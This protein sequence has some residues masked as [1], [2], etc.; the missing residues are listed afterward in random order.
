MGL[1]RMCARGKQGIAGW[2]LLLQAAAAMATALLLLLS[3]AALRQAP[4]SQPAAPQGDAPL[5]LYVLRGSNASDGLL[6][7]F[8]KLQWELGADRTFLLFD[9]TR[10]PWRFGNTVRASSSRGPGSPNVVLFNQAEGVATMRG[11]AD[12]M[13]VPVVPVR[14]VPVLAQACAEVTAKQ[15]GS[16]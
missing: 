12:E 16:K 13:Q 6:A 10:G 2:A 4:P 15:A 1:A 9:D 14:L 3:S 11:V 5:L 8:Q 7:A